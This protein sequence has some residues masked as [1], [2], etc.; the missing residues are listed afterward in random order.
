MDSKSTSLASSAPRPI[1][2]TEAPVRRS[3]RR[4]E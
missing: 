2:A 4:A 3:A 1:I